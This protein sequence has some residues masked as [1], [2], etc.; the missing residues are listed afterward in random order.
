MKKLLSLFVVVLL[1]PQ[2]LVSQAFAAGEPL[3][4]KQVEWPF[5]GPLGRFDQVSIQRGFQVFKEVCSSCHSAKRV[6][7]RNLQDIGLSEAE[8]KSLAATYQIHDGPDE[9]GDMFDR[10]GRP[11]DHI[12][13]PFAN[14]QAAAAA[15]GG[16][17]PPDLS[18]MIKARHDGPD[19]V[20]SILTSYDQPKPAEVE[21]P[22]NKHY[23]PY[24]PNYA[25]SMPRPLSDGQVT[26]QDG[27]QATTD[28]M[29]KDVVNF[30]Q[31]VSEPEMQVRKQTGLKAL[32]F[33]AVFT[34][35]FYIAKK[36]IWAR[37]GQ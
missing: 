20:Y 5:N 18:L 34:V 30:L 27:T 24:F 25:I 8:V 11:S 29:A 6:A 16:A 13:G 31:W 35:F 7:F 1:S 17:A 22:E 3:E 36:R 4:P 12:P 33:L 23:N 26:F 9:N 10:P 37:I 14:K 15:N 21:I 32:I 19:Y 28:Q 2:I